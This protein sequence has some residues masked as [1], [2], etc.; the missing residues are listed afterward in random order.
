MKKAIVL[1]NMGGPNDLSEVRMF[2]D[3]MFNDENIISIKNRILR[4][5]VAFMIASRRE[6]KAKDNYAKIGGKSPLNGITNKLCEKLS[7]I[8]KENLYV[9]A[10]RYVPPFSG[11]VI[12][13]LRAKNIEEVV[14]FS[15]YP[16]YSKTTTKSSIDDFM[17]SA[18]KLDFNP[19][20]KTVERYFDNRLYNLAVIDR[21]KE[22]LRGDSP[23]GFTLIFSAHGLPQSVID[24]GDPYQE[25]MVKNCEILKS[26]LADE[27]M[28]FDCIDIGYQSKVGPMKWLEPSLEDVLK[29]HKDKKVI[30]YPLA[31]TIDNSET[32]LELVIEYKEVA[33]KFGIT[34][35]R[36]CRCLNDGSLFAEAIIS[37][38]R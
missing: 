14:L 35:Y 31:F 22:S 34:D 13:G 5:F 9:Y 18:R 11:D 25:E 20:I 38:C 26:M 12:E 7:S 2:L 10:M 17:L 32:I 21:I 29:K 6:P 1:L 24:R 16:H 27:G 19:S 8:D 4:K 28:V 37:M 15:M 23:S 36:V 3:N 33:N 30:I